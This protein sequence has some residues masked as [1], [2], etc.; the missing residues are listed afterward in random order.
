MENK[1]LTVTA[2]NRYLKHKLDTDGNL[3]NVFLKGEISNLKMHSTGHIYFSIKDET[4]KIN[5]IMFSS[6]AKKLSFS[7]NDG[8]KILVTGRISVYEATGSYQ[9]YVNEMQ[10]DGIGNL[11]LAYEKL[12]KELA[13]EGLF[14]QKYKKQIPKYPNK[15][16]VIT[17][18][19]GAAVKDIISTI[20]RRY[21]ICEVLLFPSLVQGDNAYKNIIEKI[22]QAE[23]YDIDVLIIGRGGGSL[24]D[25]WPFNEEELARRIFACKIPT[26]SAVGHEIDYT[27]ADFVSDL[28]A[29]TPTG[30]AEMAVPNLPD[31][32]NYI[33]NLKVRLNEAINSKVNYQRLYL[34]SIK[35]SFV[36]KNPM[37]MFEAKKQQLDL[38]VEKLNKTIISN[39]SNAKHRFELLKN[40]HIILNPKILYKD[41]QLYLN[42]IIDKLELLNPLNSLKRGFS[43]TYKDNKL[44]SDINKIN[45]GDNIK[46]RL[47]NGS[48]MARVTNKNMEVENVKRD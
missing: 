24:E 10:K 48:I 25:L 41:R 33:S 31:L 1:Y 46:V 11:Y 2:I 5:A 3:F 39:I 23:K 27:I 45:I 17:A 14:D 37:I 43:V 6:A 34:D 18:K 15:I 16:G 47:N 26:I 19:E 7:P 44:V 13:K 36:I 28:R 42:S 9:I 12:K 32:I 38:L 29:P 4:S 35:N 8:D 40:N 22:N 20:K 21:P 30:A